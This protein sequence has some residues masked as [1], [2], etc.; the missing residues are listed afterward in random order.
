MLSEES[1]IFLEK[2]RQNNHKEWFAQHRDAY[3]QY[4]REL[5]SA[6]EY[7]LNSLK[8]ND[9]ELAN[10][11]PVQCLFRINRDIRFSA[12][13]RPYKTHV[14][15][16]FAPDGRKGDLAGYYVH[17]DLEE[18][19]V[20]GGVYMPPADVLKKIRND[21]DLYWEEFSEILNDEKFKAIYPDLDFEEL[22][23]L[24]R[25]PKGYD[26]SNPAIKYLKLKSFT[27]THSLNYSQLSDP[28]TLPMLVEHLLPLKHFIQFLNRAIQSDDEPDVILKPFYKI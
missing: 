7:I 4:R 19:F 24:T 21:I 10:T 25:P 12:D 28:D 9:P 20:G 5:L 27:A 26:E 14:S 11:K 17:F 2:L 23:T 3:E 22:W 6:A 18:S 16:G 15:L 1:L 8:S 13:K